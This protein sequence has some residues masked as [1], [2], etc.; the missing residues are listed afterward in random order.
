[1]SISAEKQLYSA[2]I[3]FINDYDSSIWWKQQKNFEK[4]FQ[5]LQN[6]ATKKIL[7]AFRF[8][9]SAAMKLESAILSFKIKLDKT[10]ELYALK[11]T[12]SSENHLIKQRTSYTFSSE[13][14]L[15]F[16]N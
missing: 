8:S 1:M 11:M 9:S 14:K 15:V 6:S 3:T 2:C 5:K 16:Q 13:F 12:S 4:L 7:E 10:S